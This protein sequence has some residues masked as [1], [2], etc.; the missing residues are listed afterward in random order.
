MLEEG[1]VFWVE[2]F[3]PFR[4]Q[5]RYPVWIVA[6]NLPREVDEIHQVVVILDFRDL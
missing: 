4:D 6:I 3:S 2:E 5:G 1:I